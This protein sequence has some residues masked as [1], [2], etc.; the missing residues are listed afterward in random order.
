MRAAVQ[1]ATSRFAALLRQ[2]HDSG[3]IAIGH[4]TV[5]D[6]AAHVAHT[7]ELYEPAAEGQGL[8]QES[9]AAVDAY[10]DAYLRFD[11]ERDLKTLAVKLEH[12]SVRFTA[13][14][15]GDDDRSVPWLGGVLVP[16]TTLCAVLLSEMLV[17]GHDVA[18]AGHL[19]WDIARDHAALSVQ[20]L[21]PVL[22][23]SADPEVIAGVEAVFEIRLRGG[24][25]AC[26]VFDDGRV[27]IERA[28]EVRPDCVISAEPAPFL[29]VSYARLGQ[30]APVL[31]G[32]ILAWG[33]RPW[34]ALKLPQLINAP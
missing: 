9:I 1:E 21:L 34:L 31:S 4:W 27:R 17:H 5:G 3:R 16:R 26:L 18:R 2:S 10:N 28:G 6:V 8:P 20:G 22:P 12:H 11:P 29:L 32:K 13:A 14:L 7:M 24:V 33:R 25:N 15:E 19:R 23:L 30:W